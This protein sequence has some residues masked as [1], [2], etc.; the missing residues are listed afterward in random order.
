LEVD[1]DGL[2]TLDQPRKLLSP[3]GSLLGRRFLVQA[4]EAAY[5]SDRRCILV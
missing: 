5:R 3:T 2:S 4:V 1:L